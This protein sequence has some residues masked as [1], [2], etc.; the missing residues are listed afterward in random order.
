M[1]SASSWATKSR[2]RTR[3]AFARRPPAD[4]I[5]TRRQPGSREGEERL[6][7]RRS[8]HCR[9]HPLGQDPV[10]RLPQGQVPRQSLHHPRPAGSGRL[11]RPGR[12]VELHPARHHR[13][14]RTQRADQPAAGGRA[15]GVVRGALEQRRGRYARRS[16]EIIERH[17]RDYS[18]FEVYVKAIQEY[19]RGHELSANEWELA[20]ACAARGCM[21][22]STSTRRKAINR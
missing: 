20:G 16:C 9:S 3:N 4:P 11:V 15:S 19:C 22:C 18:P 7:R 13:E 14:H 17:V 1:H 21:A 6:P 10:P 12:L 8:G 5:A 2:C